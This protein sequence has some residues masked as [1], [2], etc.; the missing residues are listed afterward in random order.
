MDE[1]KRYWVGFNLVKGIGAVRFQ[2][3]LDAFGDAATAWQASPSALAAAGLGPKLIERLVE[4]R[5]KVQLDQYW[6]KIQEQKIE[7]L[8]WEDESYPAALKEVDPP[9]PVLYL[10]GKLLPED[11]WA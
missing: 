10:R 2:A 3:L 8:T 4:V 5:A 7:V 11:H 6:G 9:P 1:E